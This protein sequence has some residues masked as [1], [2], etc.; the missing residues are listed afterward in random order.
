MYRIA[1]CDDE[2]EQRQQVK[3]MLLAL[4]VK[5]GIDFEVALFQAGEAL[6]EH[7]EKDGEPFPSLFLILK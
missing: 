3:R 1:I 4:S 6:I 5:T 2:E 7:Y